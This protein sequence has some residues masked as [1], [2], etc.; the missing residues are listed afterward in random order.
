MY[1]PK[2]GKVVAVSFQTSSEICLVE[3]IPILK[4]QPLSSASLHTMTNCCVFFKSLPRIYLLITDRE[5]GRRKGE[6]GREKEREGERERD[7][8]EKH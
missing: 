8:K 1:P 3:E 4:S 5:E 6:R 2:D 7:A